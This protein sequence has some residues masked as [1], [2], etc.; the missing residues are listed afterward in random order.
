MSLDTEDK[1]PRAT[2]AF[3]KITCRGIGGGYDVI[4]ELRNGAHVRLGS[5]TCSWGKPKRWHV[6]REGQVLPVFFLKRKEAIALLVSVAQKASPLPS[7][8]RTEPAP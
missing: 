6:V 4:A 3:V 8:D 1:I 5:V 2:C 7:G